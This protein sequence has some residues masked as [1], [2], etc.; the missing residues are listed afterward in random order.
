M[1]IKKSWL[2]CLLSAVA[3]QAEVRTMT[4]RET[5]SMALLQNPDLIVAR[6]DQV[7]AKYA[8]L[9]AS[10]PFRPKV[11]GGSGAAWNTGYPV[12]INGQ[13]PS[14]FA[15]QTQMSIY[16]K[17]Q[18]YRVA[19]S[20]ENARGAEIELTRQQDDVAYRAAS[21]WL[22]A[23]QSAETAEVAQRQV[24]SLVKLR[25]ATQARLEEGRAI[26]LDLKRVDRDL[27]RARQRSES[28]GADQ[29]NAEIS[30]AVV[31][32]F[33][34]DDRVRAAREDRVT[35]EV[36]A[37]ESATVE[38]AVNNSK[39]IHSLE[40]QMQSKGFEIRAYKAARYPTVDLVAQYNLLA[41]YN[42]Q[43]FF[44]GRFQR[45]NGQ[46]GASV[47]VPLLVGPAAR[48]YV[49]QAETELAKLRAQ[50]NQVRGRIAVDTHRD[51]QQ[52]RKAE[53][54]RTVARA[55]LDV[56]REELSVLLARFEEGRVPMSDVEQ[57]RI[58]ESEKWIAFYESQHNLE[59]V[60]LNLLRQTGTLVAALQ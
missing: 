30:L 10:D 8:V 20:R 49:Q 7:K 45:N 22:D 48:A 42:F 56:A 32:G 44:G 13:P 47:T 50:V 37:S 2:I 38:S 17:S 55:D 51:F 39:E 40:S 11:T 18:R 53:S 5:V 59:R 52:V 54:A 58:Q 27:A 23:Q 25:D 41:K 16:N 9:I 1:E 15:A 36:P 28:L 19:E 29:E 33:T 12:N 31:L 14:I 60:K 46:L 4:L 21:L 34:A 57:A 24:E 6:F 35:A 26:P 43:D 3:L